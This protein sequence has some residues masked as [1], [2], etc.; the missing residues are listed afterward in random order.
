MKQDMMAVVYENGNANLVKRPLPQLQ[1][2]KDAIIR[3]VCCA[4]CTSDLHILHGAVPRA[5]EGIILGHE[6]VGIVEALG[7]EVKHFKVH[8]RVAVNVET[9]CGE[10]FYCQHGFVNNCS[11]ALGSWSLGCRIDG[12]QAEYARIPFAD[13][14]LHHIPDHVTMEQALFTGDL[15]STGYW[16]AKIGDIHPQDQ[17]A[18]IG[19]GPTGLC[20]MM[21]LR[22]WQPRQ[23][24]AIDVDEKRLA[25]AN[26]LGLADVII[27]PQQEDVS[28][29]VH[30]MTK[31]R[32][33][34]RVFEVA[35]G[36]DTFA[37]AWKLARPNAIVTIVAMYEEDQ[38]LP[39]PQMYGK[40]LIFKTGGVDGI[41]CDEI[42]HEIAGGRLDATPLITH[43][44]PLQD[45]AK[46]YQLFSE[47]KEYVMK[48]VFTIGTDIR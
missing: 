47:R 17:V 26:K 19:A 16:A 39:L 42:L 28:A 36:K 24:I 5:K 40:N 41:Y 31:G 2:P 37:M 25:L 4:I 27:Q 29:L 18:V 1:H 35:G 30:A 10:C 8:D 21:C 33:A 3:V 11:D 15:L 22:S 20:T 44:F 32:G 46:A 48:V 14:G 45:A 43:R 38:V 7:S 13:R 12:G 9:S 34:D 6:F 23:I